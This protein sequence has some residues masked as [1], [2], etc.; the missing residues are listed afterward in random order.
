MAKRS[1][2]RGASGFFGSIISFLLVAGLVVAFFK[3][4][5][6]EDS[7]GV[8]N[9]FKAKAK[10]I[11]VWVNGI[12]SHDFGLDDLFNGKSSKSGGSTTNEPTA[13]S[14]SPTAPASSVEKSLDKI[15]VKEA[16]N[17]AYNRDEWKHWISA[18][19]SC[20]NMREEVLYQQAEKGSVVLLDKNKKETKN[21]SSACSISS[22]KWND[23]Y[24]GKTFTNPKDID[25]DHMI[26][27]KYTATHGGQAWDSKKKE[28]YANSIDGNHLIAVSASANRSK[29]DKGPGSWMPSNKAYHC[30][31]VFDWVTVASKWNISLSKNDVNQIK[32]TLK[33]CK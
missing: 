18:G 3:V 31:Y 21:K 33:G 7:T 28:K 23:L 25:I 9:T 30:R 12:S 26:P 2:N 19:S 5:G 8:M 10:T 6:H 13:Q 32:T 15:K 27:L 22:G 29:S 24:T 14:G 1:S 4:P 17:V 20:W 11:E 16:E